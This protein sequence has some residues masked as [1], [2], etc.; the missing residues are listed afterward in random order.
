MAHR[1]Q[2]L[3]DK[4]LEKGADG[5]DHSLHGKALQRALGKT[6]PKTLTPWEWEQYYAE[7]GVPDTHRQGVPGD[8]GEAS[9][10]TWWKRWL[11]LR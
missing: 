2:A 4:L 10:T 1:Q 11:G 7:H 5:Q 6:V 3:I 9:P 8:G